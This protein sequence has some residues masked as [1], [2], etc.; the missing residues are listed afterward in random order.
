FCPPQSDWPGNL[1]QTDFPLW[2]DRSEKGLSEVVQSFLDQ[3]E[4]PLVFTPGSTNL[5]G[6]KFFQS[7]MEACERLNRRG[8]FLTEDPD[9]LP[10]RLPEFIAHFRYVPLDLL[11]PRACAFIHHGGI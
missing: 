5:H 3:G 7:A 9:Q 10:A 2:N 4:P 6:Q 8:I 1:I 11:L